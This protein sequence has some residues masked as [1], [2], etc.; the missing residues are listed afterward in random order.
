MNPFSLELLRYFLIPPAS[1]VSCS[2]MPIW[3][4]FPICAGKSDRNEFA[5]TN[6]TNSTRLKF[7]PC[8]IDPPAIVC[9]YCP[10]RTVLSNYTYRDHLIIK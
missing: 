1:L 3:M 5:K 8:K 2:S 10:P 9:V 7:F 6:S 4:F